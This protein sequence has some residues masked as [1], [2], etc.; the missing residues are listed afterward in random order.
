MTYR[1]FNSRNTYGL[2]TYDCVRE[3]IPILRITCYSFMDLV[4]RAALKQCIKLLNTTDPFRDCFD[5]VQ[6]IEFLVKRY[7]TGDNRMCVCVC[8]GGGGG[9]L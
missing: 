7:G 5:V 4:R 8:G 9:N 1:T 3:I 2:P 6:E